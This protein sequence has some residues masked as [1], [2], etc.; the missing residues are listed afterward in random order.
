MDIEITCTYCQKKSRKPARNANRS[1]NNFCNH[2]C[3]RKYIKEQQVVSPETLVKEVECECGTKFETHLYSPKK[4]C[5][6]CLEIQRNTKN[7]NSDTHYY[8]GNRWRKYQIK[9]CAVCSDKFKGRRGKKKCCSKKCAKMLQAQGGRNSAEAQ[10]RRSKNEILFSE[11]CESEFQNVGLN[12]KCFVNKYGSWDADVILHDL[13]IAILWN[14]IHHYKK[15]SKKH[16]LKQ[17]KARDKIK[18]DTIIA[19]GYVPYIIKD[20]GAYD[21][22][23]VDS[24]FKKLKQHITSLKVV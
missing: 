5:D 16:S 6:P 8:E 2:E 4:K 24:Q 13:K 14:G 1:I 15:I 12:E 9:V 19:N 11:L 22:K 20:M 7:H 23:F 10:Q 21:P 3:A 17:V 18:L